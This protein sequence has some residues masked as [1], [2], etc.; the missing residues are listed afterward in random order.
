M[1]PASYFVPGRVTL[2]KLS[3][4]D[5]LWDERI[6]SPLCASATLQIADSMLYVHALFGC[7]FIKRGT[8]PDRL[9]LSHIHWPLKLQASKPASWK[10]SLFLSKPIAV[11]IHFPH[12]C[13]LCASLPLAFSVTVA[14]S[15]PYPFTSQTT[16]LCSSYLLWCGL[17]STF[18][19]RVCSFSFWVNFWVYLGWFDS[20]LVVF[21]GWGEHRVLLLTAIFLDLYLVISIK[22]NPNMF[23]NHSKPSTYLY[24]YIYLY[25]H[26]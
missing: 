1:V 13:S 16:S 12:S 2:W 17:F 22:L 19:C 18:S 20:Y 8:M 15:S 14:Q 3:L 5:A 6:T 9:Y 10:N 11:G 25:V 4:W 21:M 26:W 7:L 24:N 23:R